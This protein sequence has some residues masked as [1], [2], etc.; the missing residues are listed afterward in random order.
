MISDNIRALL[1]SINLANSEDNIDGLI[2]SL[3]ARKAFDSVN[4]RFIEVTLE[5]FGMGNFV[6]IFRVLYKDLRSDIIINGRVTKGYLIK[7]GVKQ[8]DAL[9]CILFIMC[10]EP[11]LRN[12]EHSN[13]IQPLTSSKLNVSLPKSYAY[14]DDVSVVSRN[15]LI[16]VQSIFDEYARLSLLSGLVLNASKTELLWIKS[17]E[18]RRRAAPELAPEFE[19]RYLNQLYKIKTS[20]QVK[21]NGIFLQQDS[22]LMKKA[23]LDSV[24]SKI[25]TQC[26]RWT[27]RRLSLLGKI[28]ILKT[29]GISQIIYVMQCLNLVDQDFKS[30]NATLYKFL[31]NKH[32]DAAKAP[33]RLSREIINTPVKLGGFGMLNIAELD[34]SLKL[35]ALGRL[36]SSNH[37]WLKIIKSKLNLAE[38]FFP[39]LSTNLDPVTSQAV[40]LLSLDRRKMW[41]SEAHNLDSRC[42]TLIRNVKLQSAVSA[43]GK[44]SLIYFNLRTA[45]C[46]KISDLD[47]QSLENLSR[48][49]N[50]S[51]VAISR[52][53]VN[54]NVNL[55]VTAVAEHSFLCSKLVDLK[56]SSSKQ[57]REGRASRDPI[58]IFKSGIIN[59]PIE[60][61]NWAR[62]LSELTCTKLKN[63]LLRVAHREFYT[64]EK[65]HRY[66]LVDSPDCPRCGEQ[67]SYDHK[68]F[69][70]IY[71]E[72][73]W[74][75]TFKQTDK[76]YQSD[77]IGF[78]EKV[79]GTNINSNCAVLTCH[80]EILSRIML[81]RDDANHLIRPKIF[82]RL[83]IEHIAKR[84]KKPRIL[85]SLRDLLAG[86]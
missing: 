66:N 48:F 37:P 7:R 72:R 43:A 73:I 16:N 55:D 17:R 79:L 54:L 24:K 56:A 22:T 81:L 11:L 85:E 18:P 47:I 64:K 31:W 49:M 86:D 30:L 75:E 57:I 34:E 71:V 8:G 39:K 82:V 20:V 25:E 2:V 10:I 83:A 77:G 28:L 78:K 5:K 6:P 14:A 32:F 1:S 59:S 38:F 36:F 74:K 44:N 65:L 51:L 40:T 15:N 63:V 41:E 23:N 9:S 26:R 62:K 33:D 45:G 29:F 4:H 76:I 60:T 61:L 84:E 69:E 21:V 67:E 3:D 35:R 52:M 13:E 58:C 19:I 50:R 53:C 68:I 42:I 80:A 46:R 27:G 70:C 12:I